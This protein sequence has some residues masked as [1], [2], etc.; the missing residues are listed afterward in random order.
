MPVRIHCPVHMHPAH[1]EERR[2]RDMQQ[3]TPNYREH[4]TS[5]ST[6]LVA[7]SPIPILREDG[8]YARTPLGHVALGGGV[9]CWVAAR[10]MGRDCVPI[11][12]TGRAG[13]GSTEVV[14]SRD[15]GPGL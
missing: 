2:A 9:H 4:Q 3:R 11:A 8:T 5:R 1:Q 12:E 10:L 15:D 13:N 7:L 6:K 14:G